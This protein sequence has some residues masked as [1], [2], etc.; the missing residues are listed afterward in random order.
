MI[1]IMAMKMIR[2]I[3]MLKDPTLGAKT[4]GQEA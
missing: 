4:A 1:F 3:T 2:E